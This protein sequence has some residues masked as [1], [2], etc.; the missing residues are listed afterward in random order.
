M[1]IKELWDICPND[2]AAQFNIHLLL[3]RLIPELP[4]KKINILDIGCGDGRSVDLFRKK[5]PSMEWLGLDLE[6]SP[7]VASRTRADCN[8][9]FYNGTDI[10]FDD[11]Q[12]DIVFAN[13]VFEHVR[14][15]EVVLRE[16]NRVLVNNGIFFGSVSYLQP[17]HSFSYFNYTPLGWYQINKDAGL[18]PRLMAGGV[19]SL[20]L[21]QRDVDRGQFNDDWWKLSPLNKNILKDNELSLKQKNYKLLMFSGVINFICKKI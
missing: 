18:S 4:T 2:I 9:R 16:I 19:D 5:I 11:Q 15:P 8:F 13:Q 3:E 21:I 12:F 10:P 7:E 1:F 14:H 17:F 6:S 20:A